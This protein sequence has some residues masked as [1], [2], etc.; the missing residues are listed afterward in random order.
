MIVLCIQLLHVAGDRGEVAMS[1]VRFIQSRFLAWL[2][3]DDSAGN[4]TTFDL[5]VTTVISHT[6]SH[7]AHRMIALGA[8]ATV[9]RSDVSPAHAF[10]G[11]LHEE[12]LPCLAQL[13]GQGGW[14]VSAV[15]SQPHHLLVALL[16]GLGQL[17]VER[18]A[19]QAAVASADG[20]HIDGTG[21]RVGRAEKVPGVY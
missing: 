4:S 21:L 14:S 5:V 15:D 2:W 20:D 10:L 13:H 19:H 17:H 6:I 8:S 9:Q 12:G 16:A 1:R 18:G 11:P 3:S 7:R